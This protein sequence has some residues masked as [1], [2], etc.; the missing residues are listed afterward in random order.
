MDLISYGSHA[1]FVT[2]HQPPVWGRWAE[3]VFT[4][5]KVSITAAKA[6]I[7]AL[8]A[9]WCQTS[10]AQEFEVD[11]IQYAVTSQSECEV[12][13]YIGTASSVTIPKT[14]SSENQVYTV[15]GIGRDAFRELDGLTKINIPEGITGIGESAFRDCTGLEEVTIPGSVDSIGIYAFSGCTALTNL[16][17]SEGVESVGGA[18][19]YGCTAL[20]EVVIPGSVKT[21]GSI[22]TDPVNNQGRL[23]GVFTDCT[24][25]EKVTISEG[26]TSTGRCMFSACRELKEVVLPQSLA[27]ISDG[28]F[29]SCSSLSHITLPESVTSLDE[30]AFYGCI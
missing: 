3:T 30:Y 23:L 7:V 8:F 10:F 4:M 29:T 2:V 16:V 28:T 14:V 17:L 11:G 18:A 13:K 5:K 21:W 15:R 6:F 26:I 24:G 19:F 20:K 1:F 27:S 9:F 12:T 22:F 25:L